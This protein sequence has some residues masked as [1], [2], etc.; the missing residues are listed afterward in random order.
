VQAA[1]AT[2]VA[3]L[4]AQLEAAAQQHSRDLKALKEK[5]RRQQEAETERMAKVGR[6]WVG[7]GCVA[8]QK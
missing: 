7:F 5:H 4:S 3:E 2:K 8:N 6:G 1:Q